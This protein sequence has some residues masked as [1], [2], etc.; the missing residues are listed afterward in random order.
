MEKLNERITTAGICFNDGKIL[1]G[2]RIDKGSIANKWEFPGGKNR[3][4]ESVE[5]TL[6]REFFEELGVKIEV[7][8]ELATCDFIN[9]D[10]HYFLKAHKVVLL[11][12]LKN[13]D[14]SVH[15][16]LKW[17]KL[18]NLLDYNFADSDKAIIKQLLKSN[19][20]EKM[21]LFDKIDSIINDN[22]KEK[23]VVG[24]TGGGGKTTTLIE[25]A[26]YYRNKGKKVLITTTTKIQSPRF[27]NFGVDHVFCDEASIFTHTPN[28]GES[29]LFVEQHIMNAKKAISPRLELFPHLVKKYDVVI[30]EA[31]G[32]R[33]LPCKIH[34][35]RDPVIIDEMTSIIALIGLS[36]YNDMAANVCM[37]EN[38]LE[39]V[40][41]K[42]YQKLIDNEEGL[43]KGISD[44]H[45]ALI[46]FNQSDLI[47]EKVAL[48]L[49]NLKANV[50]IIVG[51][52]KSNK[53][54]E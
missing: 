36:S 18:E 28:N 37:G 30:I 3:W 43:L 52:I 2:K 16:Q 25:L 5:D 38:S 35:D 9:K 19:E 6:K 46:L 47:D 8:Q 31:D 33:C 26:K 12:E 53:L 14:L 39:V 44:K 41:E 27:F 34:S 21:T 23:L 13:L 45:K 48:N 40:D 15:T 20:G 32:A 4:G 51:S 10:T 22:N 50:P 24:L 49:Y 42:Y 11:E 54:I 29:V 7:K 17:E 1:I